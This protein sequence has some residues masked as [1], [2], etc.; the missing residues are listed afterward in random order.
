MPLGFSYHAS[1]RGYRRKPVVGTHA[2]SEDWWH[3]SPLNVAQGYA[4]RLPINLVPHSAINL[5]VSDQRAVYHDSALCVSYAEQS[6]L[7]TASTPRMR[8]GTF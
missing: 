6:V 3:P 5:V 7:P 8:R 1:I 4:P 2:V